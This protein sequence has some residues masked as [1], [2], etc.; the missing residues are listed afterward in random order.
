MSAEPLLRVRGLTAGYGEIQAV[1]EVELEL[2]AGEIVTVLGG[3]GAGKTTLLGAV[4]GLVSVFDGEILLGEDP[5]GKLRPHARARR[6]I[7]LVQEN[8]RVFRG[9]SVRD[10]LV[11]ATPRVAKAEFAAREQ[12]V[13]EL[14]PVLAEKRRDPA[15]SLSGGQQQMLAIGQALMA[16]PTVLMLDEPSAGLAPRLVAEVMDR[17]ATI[18]SRGLAVLLVEQA[19]HQALRVA[20]RVY[21]L[22]LGRCTEQAD[23]R[24]ADQQR[25]LDHIY[26]GSAADGVRTR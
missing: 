2:R 11:V 16:K 19:V 6:G 3:N 18:A 12:D 10:N 13:Y 1:R 9:L 22:R 14:F 5:V 15:G 4:A 26:L 7:A 20:S 17:V 8:K 25:L 23:F 21:V 24:G